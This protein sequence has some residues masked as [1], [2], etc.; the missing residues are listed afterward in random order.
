MY[1]N[2]GKVYPTDKAHANKVAMLQGN[3]IKL[4]FTTEDTE[5]TEFRV[6][7]PLSL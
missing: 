7:C 4:F 2:F 1:S 6:L 3:C 5:S